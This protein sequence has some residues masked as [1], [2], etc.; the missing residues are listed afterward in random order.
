M[1]HLLSIGILQKKKFWFTYLFIFWYHDALNWYI[2][3]IGIIM[4]CFD[5]TPW[6][7]FVSDK[8]GKNMFYYF[9]SPLCWWLT[10]RGRSIWVYMHVLL[11]YACFVLFHVSIKRFCSMFCWYWYQKYGYWYQ[12]HSLLFLLISRIFC[13]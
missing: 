9:L 8:K 6:S 11:L 13:F 2:F 3:L 12:E 5:L 7:I 4:V 1:P 10:K